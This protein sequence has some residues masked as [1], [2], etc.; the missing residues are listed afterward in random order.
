MPRGVMRLFTG[1]N[2]YGPLRAL[3]GR[4]DGGGGRDASPRADDAA[5]PETRDYWEKLVVEEHGKL[6]NH[7]QT[8]YALR[9]HRRAW[10]FDGQVNAAHEEV[11]YWA[12]EPS[13]G[14][15][16]RVYHFVTTP[17]GI[18]VVAR[19]AL[20]DSAAT[21]IVVSTDPGVGAD[22]E[23][24][25]TWSA[26]DPA[27]PD[28]GIG[29]SAHLH[30]EFPTSRY[31][32]RLELGADGAVTYDEAVFLTVRPGGPTT[33]LHRMTN[34]LRREDLPATF[35]SVN[36]AAAPLGYRAV[37]N[38]DAAKRGQFGGVVD[39]PL[40]P[41]HM[42]MLPDG[43]CISFGSPLLSRGYNE[44]RTQ[45][46]HDLDIWD[47]DQGMDLDAH[48]SM[49]DKL[50]VDAFCNAAKLGPEGLLFAGGTARPGVGAG[51]GR[52][53]AIFD[54]RTGHVMD[55]GKPLHHQRWYSAL[56]RF[57]DDSTLSVGGSE[58]Y[59][60]NAWWDAG[61]AL[62]RISEVPEIYTPG[63]GWRRLA[64]AWKAT[65]DGGDGVRIFSR[66]NNHW[67][68]PRAYLASDGRVVGVTWNDLW[69]LET[70]GAG[71][72]RH[73]GTLPGGHNLGAS[74][75]SVM[76]RPDKI[77][78]VGGGTRSNEENAPGTNKATKIE[79]APGAPPTATALKVDHP[80]VGGKELDARAWAT[81]TVLPDG[82]VVVT[83]GTTQA[84]RSDNAVL[85]ALLWDPDAPNDASQW[86]IGA[87]YQ[88]SR[89]YHSFA[90]LLADASV[91]VGGGGLPPFALSADGPVDGKHWDTPWFNVE[92]YYPPYFFAGTAL[93]PRPTIKLAAGTPAYGLPI[94]LTVNGGETIASMCLI[95]L[96]TGTH[97]HNNDQRFIPLTKADAGHGTFSQDGATLTV[98]FPAKSAKVPPGHYM[99][100]AVNAKGVPSEALKIPVPNARSEFV[101]LSASVNICPS[102]A[103][104]L[105]VGAP[106]E[107]VRVRRVSE[108]SPS[109]DKR[110][111]AFEIVAG[112]NGEVGTISLRSVE[113]PGKYL[114]H[115]GR[116]LKLQTNDDT[117][118]FHNDASWLP[119]LDAAGQGV[120]LRVRTPNYTNEY[121]TYNGPGNDL[122]IALRPTG[123]SADD[124]AAKR[125]ACFRIRPASLPLGV[126]SV[127]AQSIRL[128]S[129]SFDRYLAVTIDG[130]GVETSEAATDRTTWTVQPLGDGKAALRAGARPAYA[131]ENPP[132]DGPPTG[133]FLM[134]RESGEIGISGTLDADTALRIMDNGD[135][136]LSIRSGTP[137]GRCLRLNRDTFD[138][139]T[140]DDTLADGA[141]WER[142]IARPL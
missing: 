60:H 136:S 67:W 96:P 123:E 114:R 107:I 70:A 98:R 125:R 23:L 133:K 20:I 100:F 15:Q 38:A 131:A 43:R 68:Y 129:P 121:V 80:D 36:A 49:R 130:A 45:K 132:D 102:E 85:T 3:I 73:H 105:A 106:P 79:I 139:V 110:H 39:W 50:F 42:S 44:A 54:H 84:N 10:R 94:Q 116:V 5:S 61:I 30:Q 55:T 111:T 92:R 88:K 56:V 117:A 69:T 134:I 122:R 4:W 109:G 26:N 71:S 2:N 65:R 18:T 41:L 8:L 108:T 128:H 11:G 66:E 76:Y 21:V 104:S 83:G 89:L 19:S 78:L 91:L 113:E 47:P 58:D 101:H 138:A 52:T 46:G 1:P 37:I 127:P 126:A 14:Q 115:Q 135:G 77:L 59:C 17:R 99:L 140:T 74:G 33:L 28:A 141:V 112:L 64:G 9:Y 93:A 22:A 24:P 40:V 120:L 97:S 48:H 27:K 25:V 12:W 142:F 86:T 72:A 87:R 63:L 81:A 29:E 31:S 57:P 137:N 53:T 90:V 124:R 32:L 119:E 7:T 16:G 95:S 118:L 34:A 13:A 75:A 35:E 103:P 51:W 82:K 6:T 62:G